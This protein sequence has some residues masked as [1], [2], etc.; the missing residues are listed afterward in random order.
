MWNRVQEPSEV[1]VLALA[2]SFVQHAAHE[3]TGAGRLIADVS[4]EVGF[5][6]ES[7]F[8]TVFRTLVGTT[9]RTY[10]RQRGGNNLARFRQ[11]RTNP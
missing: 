9:P 8:T 1:L 4:Q 6:E 11:Y 3:F 2:P 7:H 10:Q 5:A